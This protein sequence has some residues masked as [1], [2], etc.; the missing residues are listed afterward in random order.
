MSFKLDKLSTTLTLA[1]HPVTLET[2]SLNTDLSMEKIKEELKNALEKGLKFSLPPDQTLDATLADI[3]TWINLFDK[4]VGLPADLLDLTGKKATQEVKVTIYDLSV[5]LSTKN[6][7]FSIGLQIAFS[8][9]FYDDLGV[10]HELTHWFS[11]D[12]MGVTI[13][14]AKY[15]AQEQ[16][17]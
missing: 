12:S 2:H 16:A 3:D 17:K 7:A 15:K 9:E 6:P 14:Y 8:Q 4:E 1:G 10:P 11:L 5:N 13:S